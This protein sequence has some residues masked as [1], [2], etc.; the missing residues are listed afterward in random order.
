MKFTHTAIGVLSASIILLAGCSAAQTGSD[1]NA[2]QLNEHQ[3]QVASGDIQEETK[4]LTDLPTFLANANPKIVTAYKT[5]AANR[6]LVNQM[7]CYCGCGQSAGHM[8]NMSCFIH[9]VKPDGTVVWD[10][11]G[12]RCDTCMNITLES[13]QLKQDGKSVLDIRNVIDTKYK[14]GYAKPTPTPMPQTS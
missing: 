7:P 12:T 1:K 4:S 10:D 11:H 8:S 13:A 3:H 14:E 2:V 5:A 6:D 9:E